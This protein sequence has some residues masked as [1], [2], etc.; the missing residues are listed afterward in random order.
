MYLNMLLI[1]L[2]SLGVNGE[3][4]E[5]WMFLLLAGSYSVFCF[6]FFVF[7]FF[8]DECSGVPEWLSQLSVRL[9]LRLWSH[10]SC[11]W[12]LHRALCWQFGAWSLLWV[13]CLSLSASPPLVLCLCLSLKI[14]YT[15]KKFMMNVY[16]SDIYWSL[17]RIKWDNLCE[18][19]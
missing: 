5:N 18:N 11:V 14:K 2:K 10:G 4:M 6:L 12:A 17:V 9:R 16:V 1:T 15:L 13:L 7:C 8:N 3:E 19:F